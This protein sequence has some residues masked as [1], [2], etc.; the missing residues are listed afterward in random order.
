MS[1]ELTQI[2]LILPAEERMMM[3]V[4][5]T[6]AGV[7][8]RAPLPLDAADDLKLAIEEAC[9]CLIRFSGCH[10]LHIRYELA[11]GALKV[12]VCAECHGCEPNL[13]SK[14]ELYTIR[15]ILQSMVD[16]VILSGQEHGLSTI[17]LSKRTV[18]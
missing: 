14:D 16:E 17:T 8:A 1:N 12:Q 15:C 5:L 13:P 3:C 2:E 9:G 4:R 18:C 6:T 7:L 11:C 10:T